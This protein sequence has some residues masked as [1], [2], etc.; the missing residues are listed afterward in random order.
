MKLDPGTDFNFHRRSGRFQISTFRVADA[1]DGSEKGGWLTLRDGHIGGRIM[2]G[3]GMDERA[4]HGWGGRCMREH[5]G[6]GGTL[7]GRNSSIISSLSPFMGHCST[8][9]LSFLFCMQYIIA[10]QVFFTAVCVLLQPT[11]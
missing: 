1:A 7:L 11:H 2:S 10:S 5:H 8:T 3:D 6:G 4:G 9:A